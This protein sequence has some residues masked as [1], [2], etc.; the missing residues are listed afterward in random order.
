MTV[1][2]D[3]VQEFK[4][5]LGERVKFE[6]ELVVNENKSTMLNVLARKKDFA[7]LSMHRMFL[8]APDEVI[9]AI[10]HY[11]R[12]TRK[13]KRED[14]L[15]IRSYIQSHLEHLNYS[16]HLDPSKLVT[17]GNLYNLKD[18]YDDLNLKYFN[19]RLNLAITWFGEKGRKNK[20]RVIFGQY[21]DHLKLI[22][23]HRMLDDLF[24]P[25]FFVHYVVFHEMLHHEVPGYTDKNGLFR[26]HGE[27]FKRRE[28]LFADYEKAQAWEK[29]HRD[30]FFV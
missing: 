21:F 9:S 30:D 19:N 2:N 15:R 7:K 27:E 4:K 29:K 12:G 23:I 13:E 22:K 5:K 16:S 6:V 17:E 24:F 26:T 18:I 14:S 10:A 11:V 1:K 25:S 8:E 3:L 20:S 28:K